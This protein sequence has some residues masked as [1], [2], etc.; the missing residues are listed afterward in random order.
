MIHLYRVRNYRKDTFKI[1]CTRE[2]IKTPDLTHATVTSSA[3]Q[4]TCPGC[5]DVVLPYYEN[6]LATLKRNRERYPEKIETAV[7]EGEL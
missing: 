3:R 1:L 5:I 2:D 7:I 6:I 4:V